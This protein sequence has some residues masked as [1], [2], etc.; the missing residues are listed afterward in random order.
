MQSIYESINE[1][2]V[3]KLDPANFSP[4]DVITRDV[5][6][7]GG[8][9]SGAYNALRLQDF[10]KSVVVVE[11][12]GKLGGHASTYTDSDTGGTIDVGVI[13]FAHLEE[14]KNLFH[15]FDI[16]LKTVPTTLGA[17][18]YIDFATGQTIDLTPPDQ[19]AVG[20]A[21]Q[22]YSDQL[23]K[24]PKI[25]AG[26]DLDYPI[27]ED[28]LLPFGDFVKKYSLD[29]LVMTVFAICQGYSS[30][31]ELSTLY[32]FKYFNAVLLNTLSRGFLTT[33]RSNVGELYEKV[34]KKL[35]DHVL[36][37]SSVIAMNRSVASG[38]ARLLL[39]TPSGCKLV[40]A[41]KVVST[42]PHLTKN[43]D[44]FDLSIDERSLFE[45]FV[46]SAFYAGVLRNTHL[47]AGA[48][49]HAVGPGQPHGVPELP[50]VYAI[51]P[52][53]V[54]GL[55]QVYYGSP[56]ELMED[57]VKADI[58]TS[59][60]RIQDARGISA[61]SAPEFVAFENHTPFNMMV[62]KDAIQSGFYDKLYKLQGQRHTFYNGASFH[63]QDSSLL[64]QFTEQ[65]LPKNF[66]SLQ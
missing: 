2:K 4:E 52:S 44:G 8:G 25:Q 19:A 55:L 45:Q 53:S 18:V 5:C 24:Y 11:K 13:I 51:N 46:H 12:R 16:P 41:R 20:A 40:L 56:Y 17:P 63:T 29:A 48:P 33:E 34:A 42:I 1:T 60:Q 50:G 64:W 6:V 35:A 3:L 30:L 57:R 31:L 32:V 27:P 61:T 59:I 26:F 47:P 62:S 14:V 21:F 28:L 66:E 22:R 43:L 7:I 23:S 10:G 39:K 36:L 9:C 54:S 38:P 37:D 15:R 58:L 49:I 65:I